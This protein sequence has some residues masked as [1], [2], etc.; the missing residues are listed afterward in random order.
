MKNVPT[1]LNNLKGKVD[2]IDVDK[3]VTVPVDLSKPTGI[4]KNFVVKKKDGYNAN[5]KNVEDEVPDITTLAT[6]TI[7][8]AKIIKVEG[9]IPN[10]TNLAATAAFT[11]VENKIP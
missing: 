3:L 9:E 10:I 7:L 4:V 5:I 11:T 6:N 1:N 8:N 2:K